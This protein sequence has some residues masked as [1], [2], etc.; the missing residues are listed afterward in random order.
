MVSKGPKSERLFA[1]AKGDAINSKMSAQKN[2]ARCVKSV[3]DNYNLMKMVYFL[4]MP[5]RFPG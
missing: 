1:I 4:G 5:D 3:R 2:R